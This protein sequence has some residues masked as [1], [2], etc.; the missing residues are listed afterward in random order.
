MTR[1]KS[2]EGAILL[3]CVL[4]IFFLGA[5]GAAFVTVVQKN[6]TQGRFYTSLGALRRYAESGVN[7]A[8]HELTYNVNGGDGNIGTETW[9]TA[10]DFGRDGQ[11]A[12]S[13]EG[14]TNGIPTPGEPNIA[15]VP[16]GPGGLSMSLFVHTTDTAWPSVKRIVATAFNAE[17]ISNVEIYAR[18]DPR[19]P[20]PLGAAYVDAGTELKFGGNLLIDGNDYHPS[21]TRGPAPPVYG[22]A[23]SVGDP[24]GSN[25][26]DLRADVPPK[27]YDQI[28]G[29]DGQ[30]SIGEVPKVDMDSLFDDFQARRSRVVPA[31]NYSNVNWGN[32]ATNTFQITHATGDVVLGGKTKGAGVLLVDGSLTLTGKSQFVGVIL[33]RGDLKLSGGGNEVK[34]YGSLVVSRPT[35]IN[36]RATGNPE[37]KYSSWAIAQ[38]FNLLGKNFNVVAWDYL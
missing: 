24:E 9:T 26:S 30:P 16:I 20:P 33:V 32:W 25:A 38:A 14:E 35:E 8:L 2:Q 13:D 15:A 36:F 6:I 28:L 29:L 18:Q 19:T 11:P 4:L 1:S 7:L 3:L 27:Y 23:T 37:V 5:L 22:L 10:E 17:A 12:T 31:G 21:G 34:I